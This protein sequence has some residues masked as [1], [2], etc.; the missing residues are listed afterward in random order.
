MVL[1]QRKNV[2]DWGH[3][4]ISSICVVWLLMLL[5]LPGIANGKESTTTTDEK[6]SEV[7]QSAKAD[8][9][10]TFSDVMNWTRRFGNRVGENISEA[11]GKT[12]SAI[13]KATSD[14]TQKSPSKDSP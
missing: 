10:S 2:W 3:T 14:N 8:S 7:H 1:L 12:A 6:K 4:G 13:K 9:E 5:G 11:A